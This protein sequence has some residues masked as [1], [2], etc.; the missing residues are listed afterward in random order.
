MTP[1]DPYLSYRRRNARKSPSRVR[2]SR[3]SSLFVRFASRPPSQT[4]FITGL[5]IALLLAAFTVPPINSSFQAPP[6]PT[7]WVT[8]TEA[9]NAIQS[10]P[11]ATPGG[12]WNISLAEGVAASGS[13]SPTLSMWGLNATWAPTISACQSLL[14]GAS[15]F[16]FWNSAQ[17]PQATGP[18]VFE[19]G[20]AGLW[21][22]VYLNDSGAALVMSVIDGNAQVNGVV[23]A[24]SACAAIGG[25]FR[26]QTSYLNPANVTDPSGFAANS[27]YWLD[28]GRSGPPAANA[29]FYILGNP[30]VPVAYYAPGYNQEWST[31]YGTCGAPG[32]NGQVTYNSAPQLIPKEPGYLEQVTVGNYCYQSM[33][34]V[35][36]GV[37]TTWSSQG[38]FYASWPL[39][40]LLDSSARPAVSSPAPLT[41]GLLQL[42][43][44]LNSSHGPYSY[45]FSSGQPQCVPGDT[46]VAACVG[47]PL[48]WYAAL[49][50]PTGTVLNTFPNVAGG[51][52]WTLSNT[53]IST[54]DR[55]V[56]VSPVP[57][58]SLP[59]SALQFISG[60]TPYV[61]CGIDFGPTTLN[62]VGP[63][64]L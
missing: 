34:A 1:Y 44:M 7:G 35:N 36:P 18:A 10:I 29:A 22:F 8:F 23:P 11:P 16:T 4:A 15:V 52:S 30:V 61:C 63:F 5:A 17:Y 45:A 60:W 54:G 48:V 42:A 37:K 41:T 20:G 14:S 3:L 21:T 27:Y 59:N 64:E 33:D 57:V 56:L 6:P 26:T 55:L 24:H 40:V 31:Y 58:F 19:S 39:T 9:T 32:V 49:L 46:S 13:W 38:T 25:P 28:Q 51:H 12:P 62:P 47:A 43:V 2:L 50:G 53:T